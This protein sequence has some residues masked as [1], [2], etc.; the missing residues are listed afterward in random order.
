ML[1]NILVLGK[2]KS[3]EETA[4]ANIFLTCSFNVKELSN[5]DLQRYPL[6]A[7]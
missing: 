5:E 7:R 1:M 4:E 3:N 2:I 6:A